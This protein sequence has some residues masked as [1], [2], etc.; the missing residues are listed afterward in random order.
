MNAES[1]ITRGGYYRGWGG[2]VVGAVVLI[3]LLFLPAFIGFIDTIA[4]FDGAP[5]RSSDL[6]ENGGPALSR[7]LIAGF[8]GGIIAIIVGL[9]CAWIMAGKRF[10]LPIFFLL[11][12]PAAMGESAAA[13]AFGATVGAITEHFL[14]LN[15]VVSFSLFV[16]WRLSGP[17]ALVATL[18]CERVWKQDAPEIIPLAMRIAA[19]WRRWRFFIGACLFA[20]LAI[21]ISGAGHMPVNPA[22]AGMVPMFGPA[23]FIWRNPS[24][25]AAN[26]WALLMWPFHVIAMVAL[27]AFLLRMESGLRM[28][29][30]SRAG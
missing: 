18:L 4:G 21:A 20:G 29:E 9:A 16:A 15:G 26:I 6:V 17:A 27:I 30:I 2:A 28:K 22:A 7:A 8:A 5:A 3:A 25:P 1:T 19:G 13:S 11:C 14:P 23:D 24:D 10:K 12:L